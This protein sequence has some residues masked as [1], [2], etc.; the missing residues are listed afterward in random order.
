MFH[1]SKDGKDR[2]CR[3][4]SPEA[5]TATPAGQKEHYSTREE[6]KEA[7]LKL[8][9]EGQSATGTIRRKRTKETLGGGVSTVTVPTSFGDWTLVKGQLSERTAIALSTGVCEFCLPIT[10]KNWLAFGCFYSSG[11]LFFTR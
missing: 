1:I 10:S 11:L 8:A 6:A 2:Q 9:A 7:V 4:Q 3:A 5:C